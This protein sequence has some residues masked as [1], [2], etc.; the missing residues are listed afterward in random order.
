MMG[1]SEMVMEP[2]GEKKQKIVETAKKVFAE[3]SFFDATLEEISELSGVKKSTI[4]YY[5][6]SKLD[7]LMEILETTIHQVTARIDELLLLEDRKK[8]IRSLIDGYF[9][10]F[11]QERD[12][13]LLL[14][15][16]EFDLFCHQEAHRRMEAIFAHLQRMWDRVAERIGDVQLRDGLRIEGRKL[17]RM[18]SAS[19]MGY[20]IEELQRG[21]T[22]SEEDRE[23]LKEIFTAF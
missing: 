8:I 20:C 4:Y 7:L 12:L 1:G 23:F 2:G 22:I 15:R 17:I 3:K 5:F 19:I 9:D 21:E 6:E 14:H 16:V 18:I 11:R 10:F 13:V